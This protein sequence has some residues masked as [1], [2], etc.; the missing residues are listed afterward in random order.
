MT[1]IKRLE[2]ISFG[3]FKDFTLELKSGLNELVHQNEY[4]KSTI[5]DFILFMLY[6]FTRTAS[7]KCRL[8]KIF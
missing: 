4:G 5:T 6:G 7:K 3:K 2:I 1:V 8:K